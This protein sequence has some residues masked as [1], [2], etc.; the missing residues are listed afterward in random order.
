M[1]SSYFHFGNNHILRQF[2]FFKYL[3]QMLADGRH[4]HSKELRHR[5][6]GTPKGFV[7]DDHLHLALIIGKAI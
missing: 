3:L 5:L 7:F 4:T 1:L 6:L 2:S